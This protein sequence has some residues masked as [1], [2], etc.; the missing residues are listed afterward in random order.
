MEIFRC[1]RSAAALLI[2]AAS[3]YAADDRYRVDWERVEPEIVEHFSNLLRIDTQNPPG[4]ETKAVRYIQSALDREGI[5]S[6]VFALEPERANLVVRLKG[7]G[8]KKPILVMGHTDVV[9]VQR[10]KWT[11]DPFA[12]IQKN[13]FI[14]GRGAQDDKDNLTASLMLTILLKR[15]NVQLDRDVIFLAESGEEGTSRVGIDFMVGQHWDEIAA[16][17]AIAEG[18]YVSSRDGKVRFVEITTAEKT[19]RGIR[20]IAHGTAGHGSRPR[21]DNAVIHVASAVAKFA[22]WQPP[23]RLNDTTRAY[24][25]RL[26]TISQPEEAWRYTHISDP[27]HAPA[28][29]RYFGEHEFGHYS[30]LRTSIT[31]TMVKA[32]FRINVIPSEAEAYLDVRALPDE[33]L[34]NLT[35]QIREVIADSSVDVAPAQRAERPA[36]PPSR[37]DTPLFQAFEK[38]QRRMFPGAITLPSMLT[39]A[40]DMAQLRARGVEAYGFGGIIDDRDGGLSGAH[41]DDERIARS[42]LEKMV[43]FLWYSV[44]EVAAK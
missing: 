34:E 23:M 35:A 27:G 31:P 3:L 26:A 1:R 29:D 6:K 14:Y 12:A 10:E 37:I 13:G 36:T 24:F 32:G 16:E 4:N 43:E 40:T 5:P 22:S 28:I 33:N 19:P 15:M 21:P 39:G 9:G 18:G 44:L 41:T 17:Y 38:V 20:L 30:I 2:F 8:S 42:S 11:V 7:N 25:E